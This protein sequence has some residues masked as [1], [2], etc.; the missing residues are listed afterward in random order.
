[1]EAIYEVTEAKSSIRIYEDRIV[2]RKKGIFGEKEKTIMFNDVSILSLNKT[3]NSKA[4]GISGKGLDV[5]LIEENKTNQFEEICE[6]VEVYSKK[7]IRGKEHKKVA[8]EIKD[9]TCPKC[10]STQFM[11]N[12]QKFSGKRAIVGGILAGPLGAAVGS[13]TSKKVKIT[14]LNCGHSWEA[15]KRK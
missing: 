15:G 7:T 14:C 13:T 8:Q 10:G 9:I 11:A 4:L 2:Q 5:I 12:N 6:F 1:M 3:F